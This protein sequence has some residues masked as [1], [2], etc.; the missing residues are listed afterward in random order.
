MVGGM[1]NVVPCLVASRE[2]EGVVLGEV[3]VGVVE[4]VGVVGVVGVVEV[5]GVVG[6][7][8]VL[9]GVVV[10]GGAADT[11]DAGVGG[12]AIVAD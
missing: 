7:V 5:I 3:L 6:V 2:V 8:E 10:V 1:S 4:L 11:D 12:I 9:V